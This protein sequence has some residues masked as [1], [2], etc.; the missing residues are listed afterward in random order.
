MTQ[1]RLLID[2]SAGFNQGAG[3]GR[4]AREIMRSALPDIAADFDLTIWYAPDGRKRPPFR[5]EALATV[6]E[7]LRR[8]VHRSP[9]S[10][11]RVDQLA[12]LPFDIA[13][14]FVAPRADF[15][16][17]P[18]FTLPGIW[19]LGGMITVHDL[20]FE[21]IPDAYPA[22][23]LAYL[24]HVVPKNIRQAQQIAVVSRTTR[25]DVVE[26]YKIPIDQIVVVPNA[27]DDRFFAATPLAEQRATVFGLPERYLLAVGTIEPRKNYR[28]LLAA[29]QL[30]WES[31]RQ[32]LVIVGRSGWQNDAEMKLIGELARKGAVIPILNASDADLPGLYAGATALVYVPLYEGFGLPVLEAM[33]CGT[34][35]ITSDIPSVREIASGH[36]TIVPPQHVDELA[37]VLIAAT[38]ATQ[39]EAMDLR[40]AARMYQWSESGGILSQALKRLSSP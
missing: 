1:P 7:A 2:A 35:V 5:D 18:D 34:S 12:R 23:L 28:T 14:S 11:R 31:T 33:A 38:P 10:R 17:S 20:A 3:I 19:K 29:Q 9:Y 13:S 15:A 25:I 32:P 21:I 16:Y 24:R 30:A 39:V 27:A 4:Y 8:S 36:A 6:P 22:G 37:Q 40:N 26:R